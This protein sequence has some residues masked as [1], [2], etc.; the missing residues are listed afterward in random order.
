M[1]KFISRYNNYNCIE[2]NDTEDI[3]KLSHYTSNVYAL[4]NICSGEFRAT[5]IRDFGDKNEGKLI[6]HRINEIVTSLNQLTEEQKEKVRS[7]IGSS[8]AIET[9][10]SRHRTTVLSMCLNINSEYMWENYAGENGYN[11]IFDKRKF[12]DTLHFYTSKGEKK[13]GHYVKHAKI[14][15]S[16]D[17]QVKI[18]EEEIAEMLS[19]NG[20]EWDDDS[21]IEYIL[22]HLMY[23]GNFYKKESD[24]EARYIDEQEYRILINTITPTPK[25]PEIAGAIPEYCC[26]DKKHYN[27]LKFD[28]KSIKE[29]IC[30]SDE[31]KKSIEKKITDIPI[32]MRN[33]NN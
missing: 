22:Q 23:V 17:E 16:A 30:N 5:D 20:S 1:E 2:K 9:F 24:L 19:T 8:A 14:I 26:N 18:I 6:L 31:A 12:V 32:K 33:E 4:A 27:I 21:K 10:I 29:I 25:H 11:I 15:Y 7:L 3:I 13:E 28:R